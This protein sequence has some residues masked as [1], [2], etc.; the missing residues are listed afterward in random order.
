MA[1]SFLTFEVALWGCFECPDCEICVGMTVQILGIPAV[2][3][4]ED[5]EYDHCDLQQR[6]WPPGNGI[7]FALPT[8][9]SAIP[10]GPK[11]LKPIFNTQKANGHTV[12]VGN[13]AAVD[14][15]FIHVASFWWCRI[16]SSI[17]RF[18]LILFQCLLGATK[19]A[20]F[21]RARGAC[22]VLLQLLAPRSQV[23]GGFPSH[24]GTPSFVEFI[25]WKIRK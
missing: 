12:D 16:S 17:R 3:I 7:R 1:C 24:G 10:S 8:G 14:R 25:F 5:S 11:N 9:T 15:W 13:P 6:V 2:W 21:L 18:L 22:E 23:Y 4:T 19:K 20:H